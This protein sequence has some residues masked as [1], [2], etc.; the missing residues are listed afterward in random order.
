MQSLLFTHKQG[1]MQIPLYPCKTHNP[2]IYS[3]SP[4][5]FHSQL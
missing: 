4:F 2:L 5:R 3:P 1:Q